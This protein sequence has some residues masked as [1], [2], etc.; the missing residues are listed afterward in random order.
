MVK[1]IK[2]T[3]ISPIFYMGNKKKL[4]NKGLT[5]YFPDNIRV[6]VDVFAGETNDRT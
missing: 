4:I 1:S 6:F 3:I 2:E 5:D